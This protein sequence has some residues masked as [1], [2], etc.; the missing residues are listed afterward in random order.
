MY[1]LLFL[2]FLVLGGW[3]LWSG[4]ERRSRGRQVA[5]GLAIAGTVLFFALL[6]FWAEMLW[7]PKAMENMPQEDAEVLYTLRTLRA[8]PAASGGWWP[9]RPSRLSSARRPAAWA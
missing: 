7:A 6:S 3:I 8:T 5:G 9:R 1:W 2:A 4:L